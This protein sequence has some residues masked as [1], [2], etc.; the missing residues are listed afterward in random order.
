MFICCISSA[1]KR[2]EKFQVFDRNR[3]L[4]L[5]E[6]IVDITDENEHFQK[7]QNEF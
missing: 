2:M 7:Q 6:K 3:C 5:L 1:N 4:T